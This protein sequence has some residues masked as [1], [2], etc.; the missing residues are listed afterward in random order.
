MC[1]LGPPQRSGA[2]CKPGEQGAC[3]GLSP[4]PCS[5]DEELGPG[6]PA[7]CSSPAA[8]L[9][10]ACALGPPAAPEASGSSSRTTRSLSPNLVPL[11]A[12]LSGQRPPAEA[13]SPPA[14]P[15]CCW[16][17]VSRWRKKGFWEPRISPLHQGWGRRGANAFS[18]GQVG[19]Q[20]A[21]SG[22]RQKPA[23]SEAVLGRWGAGGGGRGAGA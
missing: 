22:L 15:T 23:P 10:T 14:L 21:E 6:R 19:H 12:P 20:G 1:G 8:S 18:H 16:P 13:S 4:A 11:W 17:L 3:R 2:R 7:G 9:C 5:L